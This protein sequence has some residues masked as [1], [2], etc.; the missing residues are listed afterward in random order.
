[1]WYSQ[2]KTGLYRYVSLD[3][4]GYIVTP[5]VTLTNGRYKMSNIDISE[6]FSC[7]GKLIYPRT[8]DFKEPFFLETLADWVDKNELLKYECVIV[9]NSKKYIKHSTGKSAKLSQ[10]VRQF[11]KIKDLKDIKEFTQKYGL[12]GSGYRKPSYFLQEQVPYAIEDVEYIHVWEWHVKNMYRLIR[13]HDILRKAKENIEYDYERA[14]NEILYQDDKHGG[15]YWRSPGDVFKDYTN[16]LENDFTGLNNKNE[17][18][19]TLQSAFE[20]LASSVSFVL[21]GAIDIDYTTIPDKKARLGFRVIE[22]PS[23]KYLLAAMYYY[24]WQMTTHTKNVMTCAVC[25]GIFEKS[26]RRKWCSDACRQAAH[27][28]EIGKQKQKQ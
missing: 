27:R 17:E 4:F 25:G 12:I 6:M 5:I 2:K 8:H 21:Q 22:Q 18:T 7:A 10:I 24:I 16:K 23:T 19:I 15:I 26:G 20:V 13:L 1:M 28:K 9:T 3:F 11:V 14:L